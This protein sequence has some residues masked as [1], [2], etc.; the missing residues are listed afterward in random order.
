MNCCTMVMYLKNQLLTADFDE[1][2]VARDAE[3]IKGLL[4]HGFVFIEVATLTP[5]LQKKDPMSREEQLDR[6]E[7]FE[8]LGS[9]QNAGL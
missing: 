6:D 8:F 5:L 4:N 3:V 2:A 1:D 9:F 7:R